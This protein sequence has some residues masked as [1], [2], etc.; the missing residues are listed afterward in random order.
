MP[1]SQYFEKY[2]TSAKV[3]GYILT[4]Y[5]FITMIVV[6]VLVMISDINDYNSNIMLMAVMYFFV[7]LLTKFLYPCVKNGIFKNR[8]SLFSQRTSIIITGFWF[9]IVFVGFLD[10]TRETKTTNSSLYYFMGYVYMSDLII[11]IITFSVLSAIFMIISGRRHAEEVEA[12]ETNWEKLNVLMSVIEG[13]SSL[14]KFVNLIK[15]D[16][17]TTCV[18]CFDD[19]QEDDELRVLQCN[20]YFHDA[21]IRTWFERSVSCP[22]CRRTYNNK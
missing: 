10:W 6:L 8:V 13:M 21:C 7:S 22:I 15:R 3:V 4:V 16:G 11:S 9:L 17:D 18:I 1:S 20:H 5:S 14:E 19:F 2:K 12:E